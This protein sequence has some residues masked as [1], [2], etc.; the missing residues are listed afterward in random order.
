MAWRGWWHAPLPGTAARDHPIDHAGEN[1][2]T[3]HDFEMT[4][5]EALKA[6]LRGIERNKAK[7]AGKANKAS[8]DRVG[9]DIADVKRLGDGHHD[10]R[11]H[12][13][14]SADEDKTET[15]HDVQYAWIDRTRP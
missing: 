1:A 11:G 10:H 7:I 6:K 2:G 3:G 12:Q 5:H 4:A 13:R 9:K 8:A 14:K 15:K